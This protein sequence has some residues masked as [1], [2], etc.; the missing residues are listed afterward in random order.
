MSSGASTQPRIF[1]SHSHYDDVFTLAMV[2]DLRRQGAFVW[3]DM[4]DIKEGDFLKRINEG[5]A[6][7]DWLVL[8]ETPHSLSSPAVEMEVNAAQN[9]VLY[10]Q[11]RG[12]VRVIASPRD[13]ATVPPTWATL[14]YYDATTDRATAIA[15]VLDA[16][17]DGDARWSRRARGEHGSAVASVPPLT[18]PPGSG[19]AGQLL[20]R[21]A[22]AY[23]ANDWHA[24][25]DR[26]DLLLD[27]AP[28]AVTV[29]LYRMRGRALLE[30][31]R[32]TEATSALESALE[33][34]KLDMPTLRALA[35]VYLRE[36]RPADA[37]RLLRRVLGLVDDDT[38]TLEVLREYVP[39]VQGMGDW[40]E[41]RSRA[42]QALRLRR[43]D[44]VWLGAQRDALVHLHRESEA[45]TVARA[46]TA[47]ADATA[48]AWLTSARLAYAVAGN[49]TT[50]EVRS[51]IEAAARLVPAN[52]TALATARQQLLPP[53]PQRMTLP[54]DRLP[55]ALATLG[56][57]GYAQG[58]TQFILPPVCTVAAG[59]FM[60]GSDKRRD[61]RASDNEAPEHQVTLAAYQIC[62][63]PVTVAEYA[64]FVA[65]GNAEPQGGYRTVDWRTQLTRLDH[66]VTSVTW[67]DA[68]A[69]AAWL[70]A[71]TSLPFRLPTEA[72]WE[73]AARWDPQRGVSRLYPWGDQLE[74]SR[75]NTSESGKGMTTP[76]NAYPSG[77]SPCG[78]QEMAGNVWEWMSSLVKPYPYSQSDGRE[79][80]YSTENRALRGGSWLGVAWYARAAFRGGSGPDNCVG[81][82]GFRLV[83]SPAA[84]G[85]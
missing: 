78:A 49:A 9:R 43:G 40:E 62:R 25:V 42:E 67:R 15:A 79:D 1:V 85:S 54:P 32:T 74:K 51:S 75:C 56:F 72:Q 63:F 16:I 33:R 84:A 13:P 39:A 50:D 60:M 22:A 10:G 30:L 52:D 82:F 20:A 38:E 21:I 55:P 14:Q 34:D 48:D 80:P 5:L 31:N 4:R 36:G 71:L 61:P 7:C 18:P 64:C 8:V 69:Y 68:V 17:R 83:V 24:V 37:V 70:A 29:E 81:N 12:I 44:P 23:A 73:K 47:R 53:P 59:P 27:E 45:L 19:M 28:S 2:E 26:S 35:R 77:A 65:S 57:A 66:P 46:L 11:M 3:V 6:K 58:T 41:A 76:V